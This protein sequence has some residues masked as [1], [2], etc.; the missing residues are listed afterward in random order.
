MGQQEGEISVKDAATILRLASV[1]SVLDYYRAGRIQG[2][3]EPRGVMGRK[4]IWLDRASVERL[5]QKGND[6]GTA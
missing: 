3:E 4:R 6:N 2:R 1:V 5:A